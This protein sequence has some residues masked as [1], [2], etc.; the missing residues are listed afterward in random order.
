MTSFVEAR[1]AGWVQWGV[2]LWW[3]RMTELGE[4][5][6]FLR[7]LSLVIVFVVVRV[8]IINLF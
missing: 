1:P 7:T 4:D 3:A 6:F 5:D 8:A 2:V